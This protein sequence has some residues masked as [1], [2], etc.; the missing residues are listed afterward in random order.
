MSALSES[1]VRAMVWSSSESAMNAFNSSL[2]PR[3]HAG[4]VARRS[5]LAILTLLVTVVFG[6]LR[7]H[8]DDTARVAACSRDGF[9]ASEL[10]SILARRVANGRVDYSGLIRDD[11]GHLAAYLSAISGVSQPCY[12][13]WTNDS[14]FA[15]WVNVYNAATLQVVVDQYPLTSIRSIGWIPGS[16]FREPVVSVPALRAEPYS[17][18]DIEN[19][20]LRPIFHDARVHFAIVCASVSCPA[21]RSEAYRGKDLSQQLDD[22]ARGF[23]SDISKNRLDPSGRGLQLSSIFKWFRRDFERDAG[24]LNEFVAR[25]APPAIAAVARNK[26]TTIEFLDYNWSLNAQ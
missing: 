6:S 14:R 26:D 10:N 25:F 21:L 18:D 20:I 8:A 22:Q 23:L 16:A 7:A 15:F 13:S 12:Q 4:P 19:T 3:R 9:D 2:C 11:K 17:L 5:T 24:S 1:E